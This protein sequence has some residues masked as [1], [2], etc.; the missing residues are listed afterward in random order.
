MTFFNIAIQTRTQSQTPLFTYSYH[1]NIPL[2]SIV[3]VDFRGKKHIGMIIETVSKPPSINIK[4]ILS[5]L[6]LAYPTW[7]V[8]II[9]NIHKIYNTS[10]H[11]IIYTLIPEIPKRLLSQKNTNK[12]AIETQSFKFPKNNKQLQNNETLI[13]IFNSYNREHIY[14]YYR[15]IIQTHKKSTIIIV[16]P[17][18]NEAERIRTYLSAHSIKSEPYHPT[19]SKTKKHEILQ[20]IASGKI[21][22]IVGNRNACIMPFSSSAILI[23]DQYLSPDYQSY[24]Q[25]PLLDFRIITEYMRSFISVYASTYYT[26]PSLVY[27]NK[28]RRISLVNPI[29]IP[30]V[31]L[32]SMAD[33]PYSSIH[34]YISER[35]IDAVRTARRAALILN[36]KGITPTFRCKDCKTIILENNTSCPSCNGSNIKKINFDMKDLEKTLRSVFPSKRIICLTKDNKSIA[37]DKEENVIIIATSALLYAID[38]SFDCIA[39]LNTDL[40]IQKEKHNTY[41]VLCDHINRVSNYTDRLFI[42]IRNEDSPLRSIYTASLYPEYAKKDI[43]E[44]VLFKYPPVVY[45]ASYYSDSSFEDLPGSSVIKTQSKKGKELYKYT[46]KYDTLRDI[47][48]FVTK[49]RTKKTDFDVHINPEFDYIK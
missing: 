3:V 1:K 20:G 9:K 38:S 21:R 48:L 8:D 30:R 23:L 39:L 45:E 41:D 28:K 12:N 33:E 10:F 36:N 17:Y 37:S 16:T 7:I 24:D 15:S 5:I 49:L 29:R 14:S 42:Q 44:R 4:N 25:K 31:A 2:G 27:L 46:G 18:S 35:I 19:I 34:P 13:S 43:Q 32:I 22:V 11:T 6:P 40:L 26:S 47:E